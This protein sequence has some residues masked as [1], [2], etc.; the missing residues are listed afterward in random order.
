MVR[1]CDAAEQEPDVAANS[2]P[3]RV[4][5]PVRSIS[6]DEEARILRR[7]DEVNARVAQILAEQQ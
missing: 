2:Q 5:S 3:A 6:R 7:A 1:L 4:R